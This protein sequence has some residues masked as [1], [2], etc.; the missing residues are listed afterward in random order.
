MHVF[1]RQ[2][3]PSTPGGWSKT[4]WWIF[5]CEH[6]FAVVNGNDYFGSPSRYVPFVH[7]HAGTC[8]V[9]LCPP[10]VQ[11]CQAD[12]LPKVACTCSQRACTSHVHDNARLTPGVH[13]QLLC[14]NLQWYVGLLQCGGLGTLCM[15]LIGLVLA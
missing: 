3:I 4:S 9:A 7:L 10:A 11:A 1:C 2:N 8:L 12:A 13:W 5:A 6:R 15:L 14:D